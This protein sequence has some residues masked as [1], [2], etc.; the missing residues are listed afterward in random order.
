VRSSL[1]PQAEFVETIE[2]GCVAAIEVL[3]RGLKAPPDFYA[4]RSISS[5]RIEY[6]LVEHPLTPERRTD[7]RPRVSALHE[8]IP[9]IT[10]A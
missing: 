1:S 8:G 9:P 4:A 7:L 10:P 3:A 2:A 5:E 6:E